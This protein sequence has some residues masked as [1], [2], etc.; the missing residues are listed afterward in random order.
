MNILILYYL[1]VSKNLPRANLPL[2]TNNNSNTNSLQLTIIF[3]TIWK[4]IILLL[5]LFVFAMIVVWWEMENVL[6]PPYDLL[7][8]SH[9]LLDHTLIF[10]RKENL[11][12]FNVQAPIQVL[13][14]GCLEGL[15]KVV[16]IVV[17][18]SCICLQHCCYTSS[19]SSF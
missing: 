4:L 16:Y 15:F 10:H 3:R 17:T 2:W 14:Y 8:C 6:P 7:E 19:S 5:F 13:A 12:L 1:K 18:K 11:G 9:A